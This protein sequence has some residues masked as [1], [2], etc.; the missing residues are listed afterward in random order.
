M[1][2]LPYCVLSIIGSH[3][4]YMDLIRLNSCSRSVREATV[5][6]MTHVVN[7]LHDKL[8]IWETHLHNS[9]TVYRE[10]HVVIDTSEWSS[11]SFTKAD[12]FSSIEERILWPDIGALTGCQVDARY[13][14]VYITGNKHSVDLTVQRIKEWTPLFLKNI[15]AI[16]FIGHVNTKSSLCDT[17]MES[18]SHVPELCVSEC[19][20]ITSDTFPQFTR[21]LKLTIDNCALNLTVDRFAHVVIQLSCV[22]ELRHLNWYCKNN[23]VEMFKSPHCLSFIS[24]QNI[25]VLSKSPSYYH[26]FTRYHLQP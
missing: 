11:A 23:T 26:W 19:D 21:L 10:A 12:A 13:V 25:G 14:Y 17:H 7:A 18:F 5:H 1:E 3:L 9:I 4:D 24:L 16:S 6:L 22:H 20:S 15:V 2:S 8:K